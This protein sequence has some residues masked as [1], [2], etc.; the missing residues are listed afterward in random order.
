MSKSQSNIITPAP[1]TK[2]LNLYLS[3]LNLVYTQDLMGHAI[4]EGCDS[5]LFSYITFNKK[6]KEEILSVLKPIKGSRVMID[7]GAHTFQQTKHN[8]DFDKFVKEYADFLCEY[9]EYITSYVQLDIEGKVGLKKVE[10]WDDYLYKR[11]G[12]KPISVWH[13]GRGWDYYKNY[14]CKN[15]DYVG[16]S[17]FVFQGELEVPDKFVDLFC[18]TAHDNGCMIHGFAYTKA[19]LCTR[20]FDSVDSSSW[21]SGGRF[22][23][24]HKFDLKKKA[25]V[26]DM[27]IR[28]YSGH[29]IRIHKHNISEWV[30]YQKFAKTIP[31][32]LV[33][34]KGGEEETPIIVK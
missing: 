28:G 11:T 14:M 23:S 10:E 24:I 17:A 4:K 19:D 2:G 18:K 31:S 7:S 21:S 5:Y 13:R 6:S 1:E 30:K 20:H 15:Y 27:S 26:N 8:I 3:S 32:G 12:R 16:F 25:I 22:G 34:W 9:G 33:T 29:H